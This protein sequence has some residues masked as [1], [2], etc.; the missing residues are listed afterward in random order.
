MWH[1]NWIS[2]KLSMFSRYKKEDR[3]FQAEGVC[4]DKGPDCWVHMSID[5]EA[6]FP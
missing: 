4:K 3:L 5:L 1:L 2:K 6:Y